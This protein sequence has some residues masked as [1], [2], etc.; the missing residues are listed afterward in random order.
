MSAE[1]FKKARPVTAVAAAN[2]TG[3]AVAHQTR[4][5]LRAGEDGAPPE[6]RATERVVFRLTDAEH[7]RFRDFL[8]LNRCTRQA[9]L[10]DL[11]VAA[12]DNAA[13]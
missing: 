2:V 10:R 7:E 4:A 6:P 12:M 9:F 8:H 5:F 1:G 3:A 11:L 13:T